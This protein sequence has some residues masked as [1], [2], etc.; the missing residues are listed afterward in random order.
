MI[1]LVIGVLGFILLLIAY[2]LS[3]FAVL[4]QESFYF[5]MLNFIGAIM[6][7]YYIKGYDNFTITLLPMIWAFVALCYMIPHIRRRKNNNNHNHQKKN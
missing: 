7:A 6:M 3:L 5:N 1:S 2:I 4:D